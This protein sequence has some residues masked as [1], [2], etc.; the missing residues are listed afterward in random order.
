LPADSL[1]PKRPCRECSER[2]A[3]TYGY[4]VVVAFP[5]ESDIDGLER[6]P[7]GSRAVRLL[8]PRIEDHNL[9]AMSAPENGRDMV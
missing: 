4:E 8:S 7:V 6:D 5:P 3:D 1:T 9:R 2:F